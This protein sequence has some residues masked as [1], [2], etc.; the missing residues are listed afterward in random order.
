MNTGTTQEQRTRGGRILNKA[1]REQVMQLSR[2]LP[3]TRSVLKQ[4][5]ANAT[6]GQ[7]GFLADLFQAENLSR[8][9]SKRHRL[10]RAAGFPQTKGLDGYE[11]EHGRVPIRLGTK[12]AHQS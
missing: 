5:V 9:Q 4:A 2:N 3:L 8:E 7:L 10:T 11:R 12:T 6:P 1:T